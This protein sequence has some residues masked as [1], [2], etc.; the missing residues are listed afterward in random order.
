MSE[1]QR[2]IPLSLL[3]ATLLWGS[4]CDTLKA[5]KLA[6]REVSKH[7]DELVKLL[8]PHETYVYVGDD[9]ELHFG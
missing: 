1:S 3:V 6:G 5:R 7:M 4:G 8:F 2:F 9:G